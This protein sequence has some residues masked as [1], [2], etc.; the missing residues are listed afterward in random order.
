MPRNKIAAIDFEAS[1]T[2]V[3]TGQA[4]EL[5]LAKHM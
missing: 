2:L 4:A 1:K 5:V 3:R